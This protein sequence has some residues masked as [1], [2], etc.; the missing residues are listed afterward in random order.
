MRRNEKK[1]RAQRVLALFSKKGP[2]NPSTHGAAPS[3]DFS[4]PYLLFLSALAFWCLGFLGITYV[5]WRR[6]RE[7]AKGRDREKDSSGPHSLAEC[8]PVDLTSTA[9]HHQEGVKWLHEI[10]ERTAATFPNRPCFRLAGAPSNSTLTFAEFGLYANAVKQVLLQGSMGDVSSTPATVTQP[11]SFVALFLPTRGC[12]EAFVAQLGAW[13]GGAAVVVLDPELPD[14]VLRNMIEDCRPVIVLT[15]CPETLPGCGTTP[16]EARRRLFRRQASDSDTVRLVGNSS[17]SPSS[18][19]RNRS[20]LAEDDND[21]VNAP[22][23]FDI[24]GFLKQAGERV[25]VGLSA[26]SQPILPQPPET[27][28]DDPAKRFASLYYTSGT[29]GKPKAVLT[30]HAGYVNELLARAD[31]VDFIPGLDAC[32]G[33]A[34]MTWDSSIQETLGAWVAGCLVVK[35]TQEQIRSG[36]DLVALLQR[37]RVTQLDCVPSLLPTMTADPQNNLPLLRIVTLGGEAVP[38][39]VVDLWTCGGFRRLITNYGPTEASIEFCQTSL[40]DTDKH[41]SLG[42]P[43]MNCSVHL[44]DHTKVSYPA[45]VPPGEPTPCEQTGTR[46]YTHMP[47]VPRGEVGEICLG[48]IQLAFG[49]LHQPEAT[50]EKFIYHPD[51]GRLYRTGDLGLLQEKSNTLLFKG[52][53]DHQVKI[54][55]HRVELQGI[56]TALNQVVMEARQRLSEQTVRMK[57]PEEGGPSQLATIT[58]DKHVAACTWVVV[59]KIGEKLVAFLQQQDEDPGAG[60]RSRTPEPDPGAGPRNAN[61]PTTISPSTFARIYFQRCCR[62][63]QCPPS[64]YTS[65]SYPC[66]RRVEKSTVN[67]SRTYMRKLLGRRKIPQQ[68]RFIPVPKRRR[69]TPMSWAA[70][71]PPRVEA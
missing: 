4:T 47:V 22:P 71:S 19:R 54:R 63:T 26:T 12:W 43:F 60:P 9:M 8:E 61:G 42:A 40:L 20:C 67:P 11:D 41:V 2:R 46:F 51:L 15:G 44:L 13:Q 34:S 50:A 53:I 21:Y 3:P 57:T 27:W 31:Y 37:E 32:A 10:F 69:S 66:S 1:G 48:G 65:R 56:E 23:V 25:N 5:L 29:T 68:S 6:Y 70:S 33:C 16:A 64:L 49:Y 52:R 35:L 7:T 58:L 14:E 24:V 30:A 28:L 17:S 55:G 45:G 38:K 62:H 39:S 59:T 36:P 18:D